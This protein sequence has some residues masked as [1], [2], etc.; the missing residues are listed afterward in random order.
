MC[1]GNA[2]HLRERGRSAYKRKHRGHR[3]PHGLAVKRCDEASQYPALLLSC[4]ML[5]AVPLL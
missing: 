5:E 1:R 3:Q 4:Y 2:E